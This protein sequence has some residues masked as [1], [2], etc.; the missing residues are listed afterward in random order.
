M[1]S[2]QRGSKIGKNPMLQKRNFVDQRF[3]TGKVV[4][5][6]SHADPCRKR[7]IPHTGLV[8]PFVSK[9]MQRSFNDFVAITH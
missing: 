6:V 7:N 2:E 9:A 5:K 4:V 8:E 3:L 1:I